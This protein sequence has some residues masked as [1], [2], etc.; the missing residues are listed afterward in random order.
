VNWQ[1]AF[2]NISA[3]AFGV[4]TALVMDSTDAASLRFNTA[5]AN[6]SSNPTTDKGTLAR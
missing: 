3:L 6:G 4:Y 2:T 5:E 1:L